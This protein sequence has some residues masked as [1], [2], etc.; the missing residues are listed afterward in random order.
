MAQLPLTG[1]GHPCYGLT[2]AGTVLHGAPR[3]NGNS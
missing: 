1:V 3:P 2:G